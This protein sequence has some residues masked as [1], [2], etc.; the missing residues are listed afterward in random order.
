MHD[1]ADEHARVKTTRQDQAFRLREMVLHGTA[2]AELAEAASPPVVTVCGAAAGVGTTTVAIGLAMALAR[3]GHRPVL[4]D[5]NFRSPDIAR[6]CRID[7]G[8]TIDDIMTG[9]RTAQEVLQPGPAG[10]GVV[11]GK[12]MP[13][14]HH[15]DVASAAAQLVARLA[16]LGPRADFIVLDAGCGT[17]APVRRLWQVARLVLLVTTP[18]PQ[19]VMDAYAAIKFVTSDI[20]D[21]V[22]CAVVNR[23][24]HDAAEIHRRIQQTCQQFLHLRI[25]RGPSI[26]ADRCAAEPDGGLPLH[27]QNCP[28]AKQFSQLADQV[29]RI[30]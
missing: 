17:G 13:S 26:P 19:S 24:D 28:V 5:A 20:S 14:R 1:Q 15:R 9:H 7:A 30:L 11:A 23:S 18:D 16:R 27:T 8:G 25:G 22:L 12:S 6:R 21:P 3:R 10:I 4:V 29:A 2:G